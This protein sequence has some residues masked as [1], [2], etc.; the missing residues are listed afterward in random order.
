MVIKMYLCSKKSFSGNFPESKFNF[1]K[2]LRIHYR[3]F[4]EFRKTETTSIYNILSA[5]Y[6][7]IL[8]ESQLSSLLYIDSMY[9]YL[10]SGFPPSGTFLNIHLF[11]S[12]PKNQLTHLLTHSSELGR[13]ALLCKLYK[14]QL[15][16]PSCQY[17][18]FLQIYEAIPQ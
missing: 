15:K 11:H 1:R 6:C 13:Q 9:N 18:S 12:P 16:F 14:I 10:D 7:I 17:L 5:S 4:P 2:I 3:K 8:L